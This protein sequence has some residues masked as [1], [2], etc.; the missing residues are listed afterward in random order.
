LPHEDAVPGV[1]VQQTLGCA[2]PEGQAPTEPFTSEVETAC[3]VVPLRP[4]ETLPLH[5]ERTRAGARMAPDQS[6]AS[7]R[8]REE[9]ER[10]M[11]VTSE[12]DGV[13]GF[14]SVS[15]RPGRIS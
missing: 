1:A 5:A 11:V 8:I 2:A 4:T 12:G 9:E 3:I 15:G 6:Q 7:G 13:C 10:V 14:R